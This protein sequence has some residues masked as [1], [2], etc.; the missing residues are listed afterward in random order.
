M[1]KT[2]GSA[3]SGSSGKV[4]TGLVLG[5]LLVIYAL[6]FLDRAIIVILAEPIKHDLK[7]NDTQL[8]LMAGLAFALL[9]TI[10]GIPFARFAD[11]PTTNR[12]TLISLCLATWSAMTVLSG[13]ARNFG[14]MLLARVG[15]GV[16]EAGCTPTAH[17]LIADIV[18]ASKRTSAL[19]LYGAGIPLGTLLGMVFGGLLT[20][21]Y[22]W[23]NAFIA[24]G[25]P[26]IVIALIVVAIIKDPRRIS[27]PAVKSV[28]ADR[29]GWSETYMHIRE[30]LSSRPFLHL[31]VGSSLVSFLGYSTGVWTPVFFIRSHGLTP[32]Q[33]GLWL[34]LCQGI[35][36]MI[37]MVLGGVLADRMSGPRKENTLVVPAI[38]LVASA[39]VFIVVYSLSDW[40][41]AFM[42]S[43]ISSIVSSFYY[44]PVF[45]TGQRLAGAESRALASAILIF[46]Q[47]L[48]GLGL[49]PLAFGAL[50]DWLAGQ[51]GGESVRWAMLTAA[52]L[53]VVPAFFFWRSQRLI[54][55]HSFKDAPV[56]ALPSSGVVI[57]TEQVN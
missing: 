19:A 31:L 30:L 42:V 22:G 4:P 45:S 36:G 5:I 24:A 25:A 34:G 52:C 26:G 12:V 41:L 40:R 3:A 32:G 43:C 17:S 53:H 39:P 15:V 38:G 20:D 2:V 8:G 47:N 56:E 48:I 23:R 10:L 50:S 55:Q 44:G 35:S 33:V 7:L 18:P 1:T 6:N 27:A 54:A 16:G 14:E 51:V 29:V 57:K 11:R 13:W 21:L 49:G 46:A 9:Y 37:G 28:A